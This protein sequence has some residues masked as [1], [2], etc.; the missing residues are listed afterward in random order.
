MLLRSSCRR[1]LKYD[2]LPT[3]YWSIKH[4]LASTQHRLTRFMKLLWTTHTVIHTNRC[5]RWL[6]LIMTTWSRSRSE[7]NWLKWEMLAAEH[8]KQSHVQETEV[9]EVDVRTRTWHT[10]TK[11]TVT[12][13]VEYIDTRPSSGRLVQLILKCVLQE[14]LSLQS[15]VWS[16]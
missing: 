10:H 14:G 1:R 9:R 4:H 12:D 16:L 7:I 6:L 2:T 13:F 11:T 3:F 5:S 15:F 8:H